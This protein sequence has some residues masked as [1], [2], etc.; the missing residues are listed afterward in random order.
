MAGSSSFSTFFSSA[1]AAAGSSF[2][3]TSSVVGLA[4]KKLVTSFSSVA[5]ASPD[6]AF[7]S[8]SASSLALAMIS[9]ISFCW[10]RASFSACLSSSVFRSPTTG[11]STRLEKKIIFLISFADEMRSFCDLDVEMYLSKYFRATSSKISLAASRLSLTASMAAVMELRSSGLNRSTPA[12]SALETVL[13]KMSPQSS[14][15]M[16]SL[17]SLGTHRSFWS[18]AISASSASVMDF[19]SKKD[20][21]FCLYRASC[22]ARAASLSHWTLSTSSPSNSALE[23][24]LSRA[25]EVTASLRRFLYAVSFTLFS[26]DSASFGPMPTM[27]RRLLASDA[28]ES[29]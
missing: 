8:F 25:P 9:W 5:A 20:D 22:R 17:A 3:A 16:A 2:S 24:A 29:E 21:S 11:V 4:S 1:G 6:S 12:A 19:L 7:F 14:L 15:W 13:L 18:L 10:A 27:K 23:A 28:S 26:M